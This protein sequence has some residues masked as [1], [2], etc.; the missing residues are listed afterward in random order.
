MITGREPRGQSLLAYGLLSALA[1]VVFGSLIGEYLGIEGWFRTK[2]WIWF[3]S[4]GFEY[5]D[6][7]RFWQILLTV[8]LLFWVIILF[9]GLRGRLQAST[10]EYALA[11]F[12]FGSVDSGI[13]RGW[14][15]RSPRIAL[16]NYPISGASGLCISGGRLPG[17]FHDDHGRLRF[18][19]LG[20][21]A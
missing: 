1:I 21:S 2:A 11:V 17:T 9:R 18:V 15:A 5:L 12:L 7:G 19:L 6:L 10:W 8:G 14:S 16:H 3:G 13:L 20:V 4:Q